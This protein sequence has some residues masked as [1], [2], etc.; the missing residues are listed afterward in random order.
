MAKKINQI[1]IRFTDEQWQELKDIAIKA[2][3][4][5]NDIVSIYDI[6]KT[7]IAVFVKSEKK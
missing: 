2:T 4:K 7:A 5:S 6:V 1:N 3:V